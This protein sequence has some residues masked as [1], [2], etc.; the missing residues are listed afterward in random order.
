MG[1]HCDINSSLCVST[2]ATDVAAGGSCPA[3]SGLAWSSSH[4]RCVQCLKSNIVLPFSTPTVAPLDHYRSGYI[5]NSDGNAVPPLTET[6]A[7]SLATQ[8]PSFLRL[9]IL[10][11]II[12]SELGYG[13]LWL[14]RHR[15]KQYRALHYEQHD[16]DGDDDYSDSQDDDNSERLL[17]EGNASLHPTD[18]SLSK[19]PLPPNDAH[20]RFKDNLRCCPTEHTMNHKIAQL[21]EESS[22]S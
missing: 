14:Y 2:K 17:M 20:E 8:L 22:S 21:R 6:M 13:L 10:I 19:L 12:L 7:D 18:H 4:G 15:I 3:A 1:F 5:C 16:S 9:G 11:C